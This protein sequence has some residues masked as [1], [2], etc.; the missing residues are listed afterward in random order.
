MDGILGKTRWDAGEADPKMP[1]PLLEEVFKVQGIPEYNF[2][3]PSHQNRLT[4]ALRTPGRGVV[5]EGP[6]GIG[7]STAVITTLHDLGLDQRVE[8]L[9]ARDLS[10]I[11]IIHELPTWKDFGTVIIDDFHR[12]PVDEQGRIADL[13]KILADTESATSKLV[14]IGINQAG[15]NLINFAP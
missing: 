7:K 2:V 6:S 15:A 10:D 13:L 5:I 3:V 9:S 1:T 12:L 8:M 4:V 11:E 14:I